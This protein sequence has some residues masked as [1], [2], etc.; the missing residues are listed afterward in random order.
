MAT[1]PRI[2]FT[3]GLHVRFGSL[4]FLCT[5]VNYDLV[6]LPPS[7]DIDAISE[8]LPSLCLCT[9][10]GQAAEND[11]PTGSRG[12]STWVSKPHDHRKAYGQSLTTIHRN[13]SAG[14]IP[15]DLPTH[16]VQ[17]IV[18]VLATTKTASSASS[19]EDDD[20]WASS[21]FSR[22]DDP[23]ALRHF[24]GI[25]DNLLEAVTPTTTATSSRDHDARRR[26]LPT[27]STR[28]DR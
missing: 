21:D 3:L 16:H 17:A 2:R 6:L 13:P 9:N 1:P 15:V 10:K 19:D 24:V 18:E 27:M 11:W 22:L 5:G 26:R 14:E 12:R 7:V 4:D 28:H 20:S 25:C 8:A 23:G